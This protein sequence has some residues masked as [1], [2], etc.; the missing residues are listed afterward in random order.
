[1]ENEA[2]KKKVQ[3]LNEYESLD[4]GQDLIRHQVCNESV[5]ALILFIS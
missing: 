1:M 3:F 2:K 4:V 5:E